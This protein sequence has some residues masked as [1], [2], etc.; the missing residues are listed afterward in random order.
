MQHHWY[1]FLG[2]D[3]LFW[4]SAL[5]GSVLFVIQFI[6]SLFGGDAYDSVQDGGGEMDASQVKWL[7]KQA[8]TGFLMM[9]GWVGLTCKKEFDFSVMATF[10]TALLG[11][12]VAIFI[13]G[14]IF[15]SAKKLR[16]TGT[17]FNLE[18]AIGKEATIYQRIP[19]EGVGKITLSLNNLT[20]EIDAISNVSEELPSFTQVQIITKTDDKTVV[21]IPIK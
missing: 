1:H 17:V 20:Y 10:M 14:F 11:G 18:D 6:L 7:S 21:V 8:L 5:S 12:T 4:F 9:F 16:S 2:K 13:T 3:T 15:G 19:K